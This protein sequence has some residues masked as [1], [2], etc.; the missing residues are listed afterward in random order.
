MVFVYLLMALFG[1]AAVIFATQNPDPVSLTFLRWRTISMPLSFVLLLSAF[2]GVVAASV[3]LFAEK[4]QL[5]RKLR[6]L[7]RRVAELSEAAWSAEPAGEMREV[8]AVRAPMRER[9]VPPGD[10]EP[11]AETTVSRTTV[12]RTEVRPPL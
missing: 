6:A 9:L 12:R 11:V 2:V 1:V 4:I 8:R 3:S 5:Q 10:D 7:E